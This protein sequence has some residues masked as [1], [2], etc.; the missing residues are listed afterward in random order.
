MA[1]HREKILNRL[2]TVLPEGLPVTSLW[3]QENIGSSRQL[4]QVYVKNNWLDNPCRGVYVRKLSAMTWQSVA[5]SI[6]QVCKLNCYPAGITALQIL[7]FTQYLQ[8][9]AT[10]QVILRGADRPPSWL[11]KLELLTLFQYQGRQL[12]ADNTVGFTEYPL[13]GYADSLKISGIE[14]ALLEL[15]ADVVDESSFTAAYEL[16]EGMTSM[17]PQIVKQLLADCQNI[18]VKRLLFLM[19]DKADHQWGRKLNPSAYDL[20]SGKRH[21]VSGGKLN[22]KFSITVPEGFDD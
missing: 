22:N 8:L 3:L 4:V 2:V 17:R 6:Q 11:S 10:T 21:I 18:K 20:G 13:L 7:G 1:L 12:F 16:F 14:R 9:G 15:L 19:L 5:L